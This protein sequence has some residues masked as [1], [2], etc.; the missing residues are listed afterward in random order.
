[1]LDPRVICRIEDW[2]VDRVKGGEHREMFWWS[3]AAIVVFCFLHCIGFQVHA[4]MK[5]LSRSHGVVLNEE[6]RRSFWLDRNKRTL[7]PMK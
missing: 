3:R 1:M 4:T 5:W 7:K 2:D 6:T